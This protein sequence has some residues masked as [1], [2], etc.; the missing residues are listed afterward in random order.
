MSQIIN[1]VNGHRKLLVKKLLYIKNLINFIECRVRRSNFLSSTYPFNFISSL[2]HQFMLI[3]SVSLLIPNHVTVM[4]NITCT[5]RILLR[6]SLELLLSKYWD[7]NSYHQ[8]TP[9]MMTPP[10]I[11]H[12]L[13]Y[14]LT[15]VIGLGL[16]FRNY[17]VTNIAKPKSTKYVSNFVS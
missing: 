2:Y 1:F 16:P 8:I 7:I 13:L 11:I 4:N 14:I 12:S 3:K 15:F 6:L 10:E 5:T 9:Y 17:I